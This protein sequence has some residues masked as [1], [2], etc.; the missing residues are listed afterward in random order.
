MRTNVKLPRSRKLFLGTSACGLLTAMRPVAAR[1]A[2]TADTY[3]LRMNV[4]GSPSMPWNV[5]AAQWAVSVAR[6]SNGRLKIEL[7][8][9]SQLASEQATVESLLS[10]VIDLTY[11]A[12]A[13]LVPIVPRLQVL[14]LP[15][16][17]KNAEAAFRVLDGPIGDEL[18][19]DLDAKGLTGLLW[20][21]TAFRQ[22]GTTSKAIRVPDDMKGLRIRIQ[23]GAVYVAMM[24]ALGAIPVAIDKSEI[25][26]ALQQHTIDGS[27]SIIEQFYTEKFYT[28]V[29]HIA[30]TNHVF[31]VVPM[32]ASKKKLQALPADLQ[33]ILKDE[34]K[35]FRSRQRA[36]AA[37]KAS[38]TVQPLKDKGVIF[39]DTDHT[40]FQR[41]LQPLYGSFQSKIGGDLIERVSR[42]ANSA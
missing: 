8:P 1:A 23:G 24:Q 37:Q 29:T 12:T 36:L 22:V 33:K 35:A 13:A 6:R 20:G 4:P 27:E 2:E 32:F 28:I 11:Q 30:L 34:A 9:N 25:F 42:I 10:G 31:S 7:Y 40:A 39:T 15:F 38:E 3:T 16:I 5:I 17:F 18:F 26:P 41:A 19:A 14:E 21:V